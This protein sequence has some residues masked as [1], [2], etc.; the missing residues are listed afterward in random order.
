MKA[1]L[2]WSTDMH[3]LSSSDIQILRRCLMLSILYL[4]IGNYCLHSFL[5]QMLTFFVGSGGNVS[6]LH[7]KRHFEPFQTIFWRISRAK[8]DWQQLC[9]RKWL[10]SNDG[11]IFYVTCRFINFLNVII[12]R[13]WKLSILEMFWEYCF[14]HSLL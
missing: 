5:T 9:G 1:T 6:W 4:N 3:T 2:L 12:F 7:T 13:A 11:R 8:E 14:Y 10:H